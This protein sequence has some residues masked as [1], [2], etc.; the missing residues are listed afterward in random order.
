MSGGGGGGDGGAAEMAAERQA[1]VKAAID[2]INKTFDDSGAYGYDAATEYNP[3]QTYYKAD[4]S[5]YSPASYDTIAGQ[6]GGTAS[7][8]VNMTARLGSV[9]PRFYQTTKR[10]E[11]RE[12][13]D[14]DGKYRTVYDRTPISRSEF[15]AI[16]NSDAIQL[17]RSGGLFM[18][19]GYRPSSREQLY[20][21][22]RQAVTDLNKREANR[23]FEDASRN[24]RFGL[25]RVG[26]AGGSVD[27]DSN[28]E[29]GRIHNE[30]LMKAAGLGD[31]AAA[32]LRNSDE[33]TKMNLIG[34]AQSGIDT[35]QAAQQSLAALQANAAN[36][37]SQASGASLGGLFN[38]FANAYAYNQY[39]KGFGSAYSPNHNQGNQ[40]FGSQN[41]N[42]GNY[43]GNVR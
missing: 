36:A 20:E 7:R 30:G 22:Q 19:S 4:G 1:R 17:M 3:N 18:N 23:Q 43:S 31:Q 2:V 39:Q 34:M 28:Q 29:L 8:L 41:A 24:N 26:L 40:F 14:S 37:A 32:D 13:G 33:K 38:D 9:D 25:A 16:Q 10:E 11:Y 42:A 35:G 6:V 27:V 21:R 5:V 12:S 15:D